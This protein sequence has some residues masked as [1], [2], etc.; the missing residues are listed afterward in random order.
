[1]EQKCYKSYGYI[2]KI[3]DIH[4]Y[5]NGIITA[6]NPMASAVFDI[7]FS[8]RLCKPLVKQQ[9]IAKVD[10]LNKLLIS[11]T[12]G[13]IRIV[14]TTTDR[15]NKDVFFIDQNRN[16]RY[17]DGEKSHVLS[18]DNYVKVT[19]IS[20]RF[21]DMDTTIM[22]LGHLENMAT[23][24]EIKNFYDELYD[25]NNIKQVEYQEYSEESSSV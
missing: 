6:E 20:S 10:R 8:C 13:P 5:K 3:F 12:N 11:L 17:K 25:Q 4:D 23:E 24:A 16:V 14:I 18:V 2:V 19:I 9:I 1:M 7:K 15:I 21:N 22:V